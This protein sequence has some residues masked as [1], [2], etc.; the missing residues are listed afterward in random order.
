MNAHSWYSHT[1]QANTTPAVAATFR[2][3]MNC[4]NGPVARRWQPPSAL[5]SAREDA[6]SE[7]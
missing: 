1:G 2:R 5:M 6:G 4:S 3:S 7:Q